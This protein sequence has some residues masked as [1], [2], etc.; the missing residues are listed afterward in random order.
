MSS[1]HNSFIE[2]ENTVKKNKS[3]IKE[4]DERAKDLI[5]DTHL[6]MRLKNNSEYKVNEKLLNMKQ[7]A[8]KIAD[9]YL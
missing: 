1:F 2:F 6:D 9:S 5:M 7:H 3:I 8:K 4:R